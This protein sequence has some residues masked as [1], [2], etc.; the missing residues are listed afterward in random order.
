MLQI[1]QELLESEELVEKER[2]KTLHRKR[3]EAMEKKKLK[4]EIKFNGKSRSG[5]RKSKRWDDDDF[6]V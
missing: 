4:D 1:N 2:E 5:G 3:R 6:E